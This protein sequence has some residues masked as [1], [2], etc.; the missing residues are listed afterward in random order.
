MQC[1]ISRES[2]RDRILLIGA[3][4]QKKSTGSDKDIVHDRE[5]QRTSYYFQLEG[6][7][8]RERGC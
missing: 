7:A 5:E 4:G 2:V 6:G 8:C 3:G 1:A